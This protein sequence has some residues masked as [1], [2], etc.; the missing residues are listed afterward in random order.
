MFTIEITDDAKAAL[1]VKLR[2]FGLVRPGVMII[3]EEPKADVLRSKDG[4][5]VWNI[6][7]PEN[8]WRYRLGAFD[9]YPD[10]AVQVVNGIRVYLAV[11]PQEEE[12]GVVI[13]LRNGEPLV[14]PLGT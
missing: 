1:E 3:R 8:P 10:A 9:E 6:E 12:K 11:V 2:Q 14:E 13:R 5:T 4:S 7:R